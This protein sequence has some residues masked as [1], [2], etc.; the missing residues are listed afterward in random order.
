ME[1]LEH[2]AFLEDPEDQGEGN[3]H[4]SKD[5]DPC[6]GRR[7]DEVSESYI[8]TEEAGDQGRRHEQEG[9]QCE[10]LH[11]LVLVE[12]DDTENS[13]LEVLETLETKVGVVDQ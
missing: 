4:Q 10:H 1:S 12:L 11:D 8:H 9:N 3:E 5:D 6:P 2:L 13:V 7:T